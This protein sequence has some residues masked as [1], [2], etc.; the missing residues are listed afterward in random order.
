MYIFNNNLSEEIESLNKYLYNT[1]G[2]KQLFVCVEEL[3]ELQQSI[4]KMVRN[5]IDENKLNLVEEI[6]DVLIILSGLI[7]EYNISTRDIETLMA[8]KIRR[9][10]KR[11][12]IPEEYY[13]QQKSCNSL[14]Q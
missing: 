2:D 11:L 6:G 10:K 13:S 3:A 7:E 14:D 8:Y 4:S 9:T 5:P 12:N 1:F